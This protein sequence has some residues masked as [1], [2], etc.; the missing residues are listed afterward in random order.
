MIGALAWLRVT[1][2]WA[3][4]AFGACGGIGCNA[5]LAPSSRT[6]QGEAGCRAGGKPDR[7]IK[8]V[9]SLKKNAVAVDRVGLELLEAVDG[10]GVEMPPA[11]AHTQTE[12]V[13]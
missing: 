3:H 13:R 4:R 12:G 2:K 11:P 10:V 7:L 8:S 9:G 6:P 1:A 5:R